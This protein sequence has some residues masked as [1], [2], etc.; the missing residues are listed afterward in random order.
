MPLLNGERALMD[1]GARSASLVAASADDDGSLLHPF[2]ATVGVVYAWWDG[3]LA[4]H[5]GAIEDR[6]GRGWGVLGPRGSGK[7][8]TIAALSRAGLRVLSDD[9][10]VVSGGLALAGPR[11]VDLRPDAVDLLDGTAIPVRRSERRRLLVGPAPAALPVHGWLFLAWGE[12]VALRR[13]GPGELLQ[14][15]TAHR[16]TVSDEAPSL[17]E[18]TGREA[19]E[20]SRP[21]TWDSLEPAVELLD[22][23]L[24][25]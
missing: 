10:L 24:G 5:G 2:L 3:R 1:R 7:S 8:S 4:F 15:L 6:R 12:R 9:L 25:T 16:N 18:L 14:R 20:L 11:F 21:Q 22:G 13:L 23:L 19:W 17:L